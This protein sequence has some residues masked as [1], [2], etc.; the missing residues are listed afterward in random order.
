MSITEVITKSEA[1]SSLEPKAL[2]VLVLRAMYPSRTSLK[3]H[4]RYIAINDALK[5]LTSKSESESGTLA[6]V[7]Q[8]AKCLC[9]ILFFLSRTE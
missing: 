9:R 3:P 7:M 5:G 6:A 4:S 8:F 2:W 1:E